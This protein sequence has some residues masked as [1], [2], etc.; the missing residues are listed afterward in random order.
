[1]R[2]QESKENGNVTFT[3]SKKEFL[4]FKSA[5]AAVAAVCVIA[6]GTAVYAVSSMSYLSSENQ[7]YRNQLK[8]AEDKMNKLMEKSDAVDKMNHEI[9]QMVQDEQS[10]Q[11]GQKNSDNGQGGA[12]TVPDKAKSA[13]QSDH[14]DHTDQGADE[15]KD[16]STPG[17]LLE[18]MVE[19]DQKMDQQIRLMVGLR[20]DLMENTYVMHTVYGVSQTKSNSSVPSIWPTTGRISSPFGW[21]TSPGGGIG[22]IY[23]EGIDIANDYNTPI[24]ATAAGT[25]TQAGWVSGYG[26]LVEIDHGGGIVTRYGHNSS[27]LVSV[28]QHVNQGDIISL[29][30]STGNSTGPHSHY[31]VRVNGT[32]VD[33]MMFLPARQ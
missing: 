13:S 22:S 25:V 14:I 27:L 26:Y 2:H 29:M 32:A 1:M 33:P 3:F 20:T 8:I 9:Q 24:H 16:L 18:E 7:L 6:A 15:S 5:A 28:G 30:G 10:G 17:K 4:I 19:L 21:R 11:N 23:H 31:E 12:S